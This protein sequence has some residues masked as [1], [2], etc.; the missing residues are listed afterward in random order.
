M[1]AKIT[2]IQ[3][4]ANAFLIDPNDPNLIVDHANNARKGNRSDADVK[5]MVSS[6]EDEGQLQP[7]K[8]RPG[9]AAGQYVLVAGFCRRDAAVEYN[10]R[11]PK[12]KMLLSIEVA[13]M[14]PE[15][16]FRASIAENLERKATNAIDDATNMVRLRDEFGYSNKRIA[17]T[18][19]SPY[20]PDKVAQFIKLL[21][22]PKK[23]QDQVARKEMPA[24]AAAELAALPPEE[25][26]EILKA[27]ANTTK[28]NGKVR[29]ETVRR[30]VKDAQG[31]RSMAS[32]GE[33]REL[34]ED[35]TGP[36]EVSLVRKSATALLK[37]LAGDV[38]A[39]KSE[40]ALRKLW[41]M[42]DSAMN[43]DAQTVVGDAQ[44]V[45][46]AAAAVAPKGRKGRK[47]SDEPIEVSAEPVTA[48]A[49]AVAV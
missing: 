25:I 39:P 45:E 29:G 44:P 49:E 36:G 8:V 47:P 38:D 12:D 46:E 7:C 27:T 30:A 37:F 40:R 23:V 28:A 16:A 35:M 6:F 9:D 24:V 26:E 10:K 3:S 17:E 43:G 42:A 32:V 18:Y 4:N 22:L 21:D 20:N 48:D 15:E 33:V 19:G 14:T 31:K 5:R 1:A 34:L 2:P 11:H 13:V 41:E